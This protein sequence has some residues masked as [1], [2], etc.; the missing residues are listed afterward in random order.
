MSF[1]ALSKPWLDKLPADLRKRWST[2]ARGLQAWAIKQSDDEKVA[3]RAKW[4]ERGGEIVN[5]PADD[6]VELQKRL[7]P[8]GARRSPSPT[9]TSRRSTTGARDGGEILTRPHTGESDAR[10]SSGPGRGVFP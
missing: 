9:R 3:L 1:G 5:L 10:A 4:I 8:I 2:Q 7:K 6:M